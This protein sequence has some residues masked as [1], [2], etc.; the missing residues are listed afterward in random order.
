MLASNSEQELQIGREDPGH[1]NVAIG[2][3]RGRDGLDGPIPVRIETLA[4]L[5]AHALAADALPPLR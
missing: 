4:Q 2:P 1:R 5:G 3:G